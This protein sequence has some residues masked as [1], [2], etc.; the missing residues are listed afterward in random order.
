MNQH[1]DLHFNSV[2]NASDC[3][4]GSWESVFNCC[5]WLDAKNSCI[6][7]CIDISAND[8]KIQANVQRTNI[9]KNIKK[10]TT[11]VIPIND[12]N[13]FVSIKTICN[14]AAFQLQFRNG[15]SNKIAFEEPHRS[16][17][18]SSLAPRYYCKWNQETTWHSNE[19]IF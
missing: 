6:S 13:K 11:I 2:W 16:T 7:F 3:M 5:D 12:F 19:M 4:N 18:F 8:N 14:F 10:K 15:K 9:T 1:L 17:S